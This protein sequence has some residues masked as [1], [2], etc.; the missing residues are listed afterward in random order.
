MLAGRNGL[1]DAILRVSDRV[2]I[3]STTKP[4]HA[5]RGYSAEWRRPASRTGKPARLHVEPSVRNLGEQDVDT[6]LHVAFASLGADAAF[7]G[8]CNPPG[9]DWSGISFR[10]GPSGAEFRWLTLPRVSA[11]GGKRPDHVFALFE[12][13]MSVICLS[14]ESKESAGS[15]G[16]DIGSRLSRYTEGLLDTPP[17]IRRE[18]AGPWE[19][20]DP[21]W[22]SPATTFASGGAYLSMASS[23]FRSLSDDTGLDVQIGV[24]F[25]ERAQ[26]CVLH[27][28]ADTKLGRSIVARLASQRWSDLVTVQ[29]SS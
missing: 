18:K 17:S 29:V 26:R 16:K 14:V 19:M 23:P 25:R 7:E 8:M 5:R 11:N 15:L 28:R 22:Q 24:E 9:G 12:G 27:L 3:D 4:S 13:G 21:P 6:A 10:W 20:H 2:L 1:W